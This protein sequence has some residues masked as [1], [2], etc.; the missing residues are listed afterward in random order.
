MK[1]YRGYLY[2]KF[3]LLWI[4]KELMVLKDVSGIVLDNVMLRFD[5]F[6]KISLRNMIGFA[7]TCLEKETFSCTSV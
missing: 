5:V 4:I 6:L 1:F 3:M 2:G 7:G